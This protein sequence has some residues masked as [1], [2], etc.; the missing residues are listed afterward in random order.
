VILNQINF[1][2]E[3][4]LNANKRHV[5]R[6]VTDM[7]AAKPRTQDLPTHLAGMQDPVLNEKI[8]GQHLGLKFYK[9]VQVNKSKNKIFS[10]IYEV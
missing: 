8:I 6:F 5:F 1:A 9:L 2:S 10:S 4:Q 7:I 3:L